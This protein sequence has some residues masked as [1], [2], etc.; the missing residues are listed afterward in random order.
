ME[1]I[2]IKDIKTSIIKESLDEC[3]INPKD[4][5]INEHYNQTFSQNLFIKILFYL[6]LN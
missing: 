4:N 5:I 6:P 1:P 3:Y 2:V